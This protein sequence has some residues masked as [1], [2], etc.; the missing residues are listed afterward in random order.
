LLGILTGITNIIPYIGPI[1]GSFPAVLIACL[2]SPLKALAV[3]LLF[4]LIQQIESV[5]IAPKI[6]S[7]NVG[8]HPLAVIFSLLAGAELFG[9]WGLLF[10]IPV[11]GSIKVLTRLIIRHFSL[12][13]NN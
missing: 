13:D 12:L 2:S 9:I 4:V 5:F 8:L 1:I 3:V 10:A 7:K 6:L 11:A